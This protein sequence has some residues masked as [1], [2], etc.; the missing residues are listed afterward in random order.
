MGSNAGV[1]TWLKW[2]TEYYGDSTTGDAPSPNE[3]MIFAQNK[4]LAGICDALE[5]IATKLE[6]QN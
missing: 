3:D 1:D 4:I 5:R 6:Q 2:F